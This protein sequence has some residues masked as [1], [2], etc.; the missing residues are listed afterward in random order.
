MA[1]PRGAAHSAQ[2]AEPLRA[3]HDR[4]R[5]GREGPGRSRRCRGLLPRRWDNPH[6]AVRVAVSMPVFSAEV[7][8]PL[9][10]YLY[11]RT[12]ICIPLGMRT[13]TRT[14]THTHAGRCISSLPTP[15]HTRTHAHMQ[16]HTHRCASPT[17]HHGRCCT[18]G[19]APAYSKQGLCHTPQPHP[20]PRS[21]RH[22]SGRSSSSAGARRAACQ[23]SC[24]RYLLLTTYYL[25]LTTYYL[26]LTTY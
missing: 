6:D 21:R 13:R 11:M 19:A 10:A 15:T 7:C 17:A 20:I 4:L 2:A 5:S 25:L 8:I 18:T 16:A 1:A 14:H 24:S 23:L 9:Y 12:S 22:R 26:L 3:Q